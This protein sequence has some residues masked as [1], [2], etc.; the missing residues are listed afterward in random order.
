MEVGTVVA[1]TTGEPVPLDD[2]LEALALADAG[3][4]DLVA[5]GED[6]DG[7]GLADGQLVLAA[8]LDEV[9]LGSHAGLLEVSEQGLVEPLGLDVAEGDLGG[10]VAVGLHGLLLGDQAG[11]GLDDRAADDGAVFIEVLGH[12][13]LCT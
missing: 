3:H 4:L 7:D 13:Q 12:T 1:G 6:L 5:G 11:P 8:D 9:A 10:G 2:A